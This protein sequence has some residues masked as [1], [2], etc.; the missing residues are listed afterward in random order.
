[1]RFLVDSF[2]LETFDFLFS[3]EKFFDFGVFGFSVPVFQ[4][5]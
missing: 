2:F 3:K 1:M 4:R 5:S